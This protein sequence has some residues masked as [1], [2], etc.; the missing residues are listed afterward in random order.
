MADFNSYTLKLRVWMIN[1]FG[2]ILWEFEKREIMGNMEI[3]M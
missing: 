3:Y 1:V 2:N